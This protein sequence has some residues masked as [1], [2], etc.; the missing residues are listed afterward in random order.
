[1]FLN[2]RIYK[3]RDEKEVYMY[4]FGLLQNYY[5]KLHVPLPGQEKTQV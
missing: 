1:M 3:V 5:K 4:K 2:I